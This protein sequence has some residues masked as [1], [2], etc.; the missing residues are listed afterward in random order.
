MTL[1]LLLMLSALSS[2]EASNQ[3][4]H[5]AAPIIELRLAGSENLP[6]PE[7][8]LA[9]ETLHQILA[10]S[11]IESAWR[12]CASAIPDCGESPADGRISI[13]VHLLLRSREDDPAICG[14]TTLDVRIRAPMILV[15]LPPHRDLVPAVRRNRKPLLVSVHIGHLIGLTLAHEVGHVFRVPHTSTGLMSLRPGIGEILALRELRLA[16]TSEQRARMRVTLTDRLTLTDS[17]R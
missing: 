13:M 6:P 15:Y 3:S 11:G 8:E 10:S 12:D 1:T 4:D 14:V 17:T 16:F 9:R 5:A 7:L 2:P